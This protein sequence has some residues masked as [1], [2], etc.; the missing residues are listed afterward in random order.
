MVTAGSPVWTS[1]DL[2]SSTVHVGCRSLSSAAA[3]ATCGVA[4]LVP[5]SWPQVPS[6]GG[7]DDRIDSPG[8]VTSGF[9]CSDTGVGPADEKLEICRLT[10]DAATVIAPAAFPGESIEP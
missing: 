1:A 2:I 8:A 9:C 10:V 6:L 4:M 3:P 7:R 5:L